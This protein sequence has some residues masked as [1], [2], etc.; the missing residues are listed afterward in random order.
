[1]QYDRNYA[2]TMATMRG[3]LGGL[4]DTH[5]F[6]RDVFVERVHAAIE[7][8]W[9]IKEYDTDEACRHAIQII[10]LRVQADKAGHRIK[11]RVQNYPD[12]EIFIYAETPTDQTF[13]GPY[14]DPLLAQT[15]SWFLA[16]ESVRAF[17]Q[18]IFDNYLK[19]WDANLAS[20][21]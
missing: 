15:V 21:V 1:M 17:S 11:I 14:R 16:M 6:Y 8:Y 18:L 9:A 12:G 5:T 4:V 10:N 13:I 20:F 7:F 19:R 3:H 2:M